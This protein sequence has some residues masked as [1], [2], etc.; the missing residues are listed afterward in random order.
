MTLAVLM[1]AMAFP[2]P[3]APQ[4][5]P[6]FSGTWAHAASFVTGASRGGESDE[7]RPTPVHTSSGAGFNCGQACTIAQKGQRLTV[8]NA[9][10]ADY[11]GKALLV[12]NVASQCGN[13]P[14]T[15]RTGTR[16]GCGSGAPTAYV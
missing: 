15:R 1:L 9:Q 6:D 7:P 14:T 8:D 13:T 10:L 5:R 4:R 16:N 11:K 2:L 12:V 3:G